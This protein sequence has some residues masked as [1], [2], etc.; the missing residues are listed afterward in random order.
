MFWTA[1]GVV[2]PVQL[3]FG[4]SLSS[5]GVGEF[6]FFWLQ[7]KFSCSSAW[8]HSGHSSCV[9]SRR[10]PTFSTWAKTSDPDVASAGFFGTVC[11]TDY[12]KVQISWRMPIVKLHSVSPSWWRCRFQE[13]TSDSRLVCRLLASCSCPS[14]SKLHIPSVAYRCAHSNV[15]YE[16]CFDVLAVTASTS[17][18]QRRHHARI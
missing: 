8:F 1:Q 18:G 12:W 14:P 11:G 15:W 13:S 10:L 17:L 3:L 16:G 2:T 7:E 6:G 9:S 5:D 4:V